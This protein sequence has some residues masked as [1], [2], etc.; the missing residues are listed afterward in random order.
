M[1]QISV[2]QI[3]KTVKSKVKK[4]VFDLSNI[5]GKRKKI[6]NMGPLLVFSAYF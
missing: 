6:V 3:P 5:K 1:L 4:G 2:F